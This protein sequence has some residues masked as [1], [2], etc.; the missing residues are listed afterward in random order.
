[1]PLVLKDI[2]S[3]PSIY[4]EALSLWGKADQLRMAQEECAELIQAINKLFRKNDINN[5]CEEIADVEI[6]LS[7]LRIIFGDKKINDIKFEKLK[8][9]GKLIDKE[10]THVRS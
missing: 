5:V 6:M 7:Q 3:S 8:K 9:L 10:N 1:M 2:K 4:E